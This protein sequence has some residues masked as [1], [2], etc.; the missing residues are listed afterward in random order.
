MQRCQK[1]NLVQGLKMAFG[2]RAMEASWWKVEE[3]KQNRN[4]YEI[5]S[6]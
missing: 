3:G 4:S 5:I 2:I 1:Y 6:N